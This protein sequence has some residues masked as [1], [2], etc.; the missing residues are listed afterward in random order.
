MQSINTGYKNLIKHTV[1]LFK[2]LCIAILN[3]IDKLHSRKI[4]KISYLTT[5]K[6]VSCSHLSSDISCKNKENRYIWISWNTHTQYI[7][8]YFSGHMKVIFLCCTHVLLIKDNYQFWH[9][10]TYPC[11]TALLSILAYF[12]CKRLLYSSRILL[13]L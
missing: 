6:V 1:E 10:W 9:V 7:Y 12:C 2:V 8:I 13:S 11:V 3:Y 4:H 5:L